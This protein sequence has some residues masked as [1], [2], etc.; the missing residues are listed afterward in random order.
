MNNHPTSISLTTR[1]G[2][3]SAVWWLNQPLRVR[4][5][6]PKR[7][8]GHRS[9]SSRIAELEAKSGTPLVPVELNASPL[10]VILHYLLKNNTQFI[11]WNVQVKVSPR[12]PTTSPS[13]TGGHLR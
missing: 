2:S 10:L 1:H 12:I 13:S 3:R 4:K 7:R 5:V 6:E 11:G 8:R 9:M